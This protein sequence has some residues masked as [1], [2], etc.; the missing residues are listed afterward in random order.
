MSK[1]PQLYYGDVLVC[2]KPFFN[3]SILILH[4]CFFVLKV[5]SNS[6]LSQ[7]HCCS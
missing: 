2:L 1:L 4:C 3:V 5:E 6:K 7:L